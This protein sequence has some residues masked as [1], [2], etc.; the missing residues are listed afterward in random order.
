[1]RVGIDEAGQHQLAGHVDHL[2]G[3][4]RQ[5]VRLHGCDLAVA[6]GDVP[7]AINA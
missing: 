6:N 2:F 4:G 5:D 3:A 7:D 1:M